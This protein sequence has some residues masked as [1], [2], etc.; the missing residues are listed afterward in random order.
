MAGYSAGFESR[1]AFRR[2]SGYEL[3]KALSIPVRIIFAE[4]SD[5]MSTTI[6]L[7]PEDSKP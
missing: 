6:R 7:D 5:T 3:A 1:K 2:S 4:R